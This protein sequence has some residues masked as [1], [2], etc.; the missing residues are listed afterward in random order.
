MPRTSVI[1]LT[2]GTADLAVVQNAHSRIEQ[3]ADLRLISFEGGAGD[4]LH[5]GA[6][7]N[8]VGRHDRELDAHYRFNIRSMLV[9]SG[10]HL[11]NQ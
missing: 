9:K 11:I 1:G 5:D 7:L 4:H 3:A 2:T 6:F 10:W 8:L